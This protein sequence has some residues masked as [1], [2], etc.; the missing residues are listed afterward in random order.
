MTKNTFIYLFLTFLV[1]GGILVFTF[2]KGEIV[3]FINREWTKDNT[4]FFFK[5]ATHL[6][7]GL[8][9]LALFIISLFIR[10]YW[11]VLIAVIAI[12]QTIFVHIFKQWIFK[13]LPRPVVG[14]SE[15]NLHFVPGVDVNSYGTFPSGHTATAF[16]VFLVLTLLVNNNKSLGI[17]FFLCALIV[18]ISRVYLLQ[19]YF[20][21]IYFGAFFGVLAVYV[22][23]YF[24]RKGELNANESAFWNK[25]VVS[26]FSKS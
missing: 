24:L 3:L 10:F 8:M 13:G 11:S 26:M 12:I 2:Q 22:S 21:D 25:N 15:Y 14:L 20:I 4:D 17:L 5:Y 1:L 9:Y 6:G 19:H 23:K 18:G 7:D 16:A